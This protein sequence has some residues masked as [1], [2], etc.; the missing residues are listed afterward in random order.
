MDFSR[1]DMCNK[2][3]TNVENIKVEEMQIRNMDDTDTTIQ[4]DR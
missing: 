4:E 2:S 1:K 3:P